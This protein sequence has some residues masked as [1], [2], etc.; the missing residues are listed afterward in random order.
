[1]HKYIEDHKHDQKATP[2]YNLHVSV[3]LHILSVNSPGHI[4]V[5]SVHSSAYFPP[6]AKILIALH[7]K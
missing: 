5:I 1:M 4:S 7:F 2:E 6:N 3:L